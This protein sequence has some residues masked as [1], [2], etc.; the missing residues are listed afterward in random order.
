MGPLVMLAF[1]LGTVPALTALVSSAVVLSARFTTLVP[2]AA[3]VLLILAGL[4]TMSGRGFAE[5]NSL[6]DIHGGT[7]LQLTASDAG[8]VEVI[9]DTP[10]PCCSEDSS[11][12]E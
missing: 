12:R 3:A 2:T 1:W 11:I 8:Q 5:L 7:E 10:L 9:A 4:F 6:G